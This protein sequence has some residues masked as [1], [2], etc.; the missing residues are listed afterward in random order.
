MR[1]E[2][3]MSRRHILRLALAG[4]GL[5][6]SGGIHT[7]FAQA[8]FTPSPIVPAPGYMEAA[9]KALTEPFKGITTDGTVVPGLFSMQQTGIPTTP[10]TDAAAAFLA[11]LAFTLLNRRGAGAEPLLAGVA[12]SLRERDETAALFVPQLQANRAD[13]LP[14]G[15]D[16]DLVEDLVVVVRALEVVVRDARVQVVDVVQAD[17][18]GEEL[19]RLRQVQVGAALERRLGV[20]PVL[21]TL[22]VDV[23]E[24]VLHVEQPDA[25]RPAS[26]TVG[27]WISRY[28][29]QPIAKQIPVT[30]MTRATLVQIT[31][32]RIC[33]VG[34]FG[35]KR[36][37]ITSDQ[38]CPIPN[39]TSG[40]RKSQY[41]R[42]AF[43]PFS[44]YSV[45]VRVGTSPVPRRS[46][47]PAL[48]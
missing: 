45:T 11:A 40:W 20:A 2:S 31:L 27:S 23:L 35:M 17:V 38:R 3:G 41:P 48:P 1:A 21:G 30:R 43:Q 34:F 44:W 7:L 28:S 32:R 24:L 39:M 19:Q 9:E 6:M 13:A 36:G 4:G 42:R 10:I 14:E 37:P 16:R 47:S 26:I 46:R 33:F 22:P 8:P 12:A 25:G 18:P 5:A 29:H 15:E